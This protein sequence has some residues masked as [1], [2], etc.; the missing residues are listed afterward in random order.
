MGQYDWSPENL[1]L[2]QKAAKNA[3]QL[4]LQTAELEKFHLF[5][6]LLLEWNERLNLTAL[7]EPEDI[8]Y[9]HFLDSLYLLPFLTPAPP[10]LKLLDLGT[11]AGFPGIPL[12]IMRPQLPIVLADAQ[13]KRLNFLTEVIKT[14]EL[15][16]ISVLHGR[17]EDWGRAP[18]CRESFTWV[19]AR[20]VAPLPVLAEYALPLVAPGGLLLAAKGSGAEQE[21]A[22]AA[23]ALRELQGET[24]NTLS[25]R[26]PG[27][28]ERV[29][30]AIRKT[31]TT[32]EL[33]PRK[34]A[35]IKRQ[36]L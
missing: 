7:T 5:A 11:G 27:G 23:G 32:P 2:L 33:Y 13:Q 19:T 3:L 34:A 1:T 21:L 9:K 20:A 26:L 4:E 22:L 24:E 14:L 31:G 30:L 15:E 10:G 35:K 29:I 6:D 25:Y 28:E 12:K 16:N 17:A 18:G 8:A 36:P